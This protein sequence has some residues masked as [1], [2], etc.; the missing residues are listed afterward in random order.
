MIG[1]AADGECFD[2]G[3]QGF[4]EEDSMAP[5]TKSPA[6]TAFDVVPGVFPSREQA[7]AAVADPGRYRLMDD[8]SDRAQGAVK[9]GIAVGIPVGRLAGL[10]LVGLGFPGLGALGLGG[11]LIGLE[12][13]AIWGANLG[14]YDGL[15]VKVRTDTEQ[16]RWCEVPL[17]GGD[18]MIAARIDR[19]T[20]PRTDEVRRLMEQHGARCFLDQAQRVA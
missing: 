18:V 14:G 1:G 12:G 20:G 4:E 9:T 19:Q 3:K 15:A 6:E 17:E 13:G 5:E 7:E 2:S 10:A 16:D 8:T 11:L